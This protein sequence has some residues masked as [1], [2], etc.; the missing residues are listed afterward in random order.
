[1]LKIKHGT[2]A[3]DQGEVG[4]FSDFEMG[5]PMWAGHGT[6]EARKYVAFSQRYI[7][8]PAVTVGLSM[9]DMATDANSRVEVKAENIT[10]TGFDLVFSTWSDT[11]IARARGSWQAIGAV[12]DDDNWDV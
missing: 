7:A 2:V 10:V 6:R 12:E 3:V 8:P 9:W 11:R 4:L 5:G 1:M